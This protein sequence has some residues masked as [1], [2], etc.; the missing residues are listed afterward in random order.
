MDGIARETF[1]MNQMIQSHDLKTVSKGDFSADGKYV[2]EVGGKAK[3]FKQIAGVD[4][5]YVVADDIETGYGNKIPLWILG[6]LY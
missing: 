3:G 2:F 4:N 1:F 6:F 5:S